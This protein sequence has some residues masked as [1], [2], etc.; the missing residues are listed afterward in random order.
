MKLNITEHT[1]KRT[2]NNLRKLEERFTI[3][4]GDRYDYTNTIVSSMKDIIEIKCKKHGIFVQKIDYH[5]S[6]YGCQLCGLDRVKEKLSLTTEE[7]IKRA[8]KV[9]NNIYSYDKAV[10]IND[11]IPVIVTCTEHGDFDQLPSVHVRNK[12]G[13]K[14]CSSI[15]NGKN[16]RVGKEEFIKRSLETHETVY[17]YDNIPEHVTSHDRVHIIC[18]THGEFTQISQVHYTGA[19]CPICV[20]ENQA[21]IAIYSDKPTFLYYVRITYDDQI[22]YKIGITIRGVVKR[23]YSELRKGYVID[24]LHQELFNTGFDAFYKEQ[25]IL[26]SLRSFRYY[27]RIP[28]LIEGGNSELFIEDCVYLSKK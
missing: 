3:L 4:F 15:T 25:L 17:G 9:H 14:I 23:F 27:N 7:F 5:L 19:N 16:K 28:F 11:N 2:A 22:L 1:H 26:N 13:C 10:Y 8:K 21:N 18:P 20:R 12:G 6:G 24:I